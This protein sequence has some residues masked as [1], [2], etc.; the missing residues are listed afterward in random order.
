MKMATRIPGY[1]T[2]RAAHPEC[3]SRVRLDIQT[4]ADQYQELFVDVQMERVFAD[5]KTFVDSVSRIEPRDIL[6][7]YRARRDQPGFELKA[8]VEQ[9]FDPPAVEASHYVSPPDQ[10]MLEHID[11]LW[12]VLTRQP[13]EH[14][15]HSSLLPLPH[16]YVVPGGRFGELYYWDS[17]FTML[18]LAQSGRK[19][20]LRSMADNFAHLIDTYG[21]IPNG[22]RSY[23]LSRSQ[24]PVFALMVELF[25]THGVQPALRYLPQLHKE[26]AYWMD[27]GDALKPG[28]CHRHVVCLERGVVL[29]RYWDDRD[30][31]REESFRED[32]CT[33]RAAQ[34]PAREV[35]RDLRAAAASGWDFSSRWQADPD[36]LSSIR[37]TAILPVDLNAFL[38]RL[39]RT[40]ETLG[41]ASGDEVLGRDFEERARRRREAMHS[42]MW[43]EA[44]G[45][46]F[47]YDW[48]LGQRRSCLTAAALC[49]LFIGLATPRQAAATAETVAG[50]LLREGGIATT[51]RA[52]SGE[53]WDQ[54]NG[55]A[56]LQW[57][58]I[59]GLGAYGHQALADRIAHRWLETVA[60]L[61]RRESKLV[62]KYALHSA[63]G[64]GGGE[65][66]L[67]DGFGWTN[68]V[69]RKLLELYPEHPAQHS[70][71][72]T[73]H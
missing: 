68:G 11:G 6:A 10:P 58:A 7:A 20:L 64:G 55:W 54:P 66:P 3:A 30:A 49:P 65:Y 40:I 48:V 53:Q 59:L 51:E 28:E 33:A 69:V 17:Y 31:P 63:E 60:R 57:M 34:R 56:P 71:A 19:D 41:C 70:R 27:G 16:P 32:V 29:N 43:D 39:E 14:A 25:E 47:D 12:P 52:D 50:R 38:Y 5:G 26:Y 42:L 22:T 23:Y 35:Y 24:P 44:G 62:E 67:Q 13:Q 73:A 9:H 45:A 37:T 72:R 46:Y 18:G 36:R 21:H 15:P 1:S 8:F 4:P 61:Y 2:S